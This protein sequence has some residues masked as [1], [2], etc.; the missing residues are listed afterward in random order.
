MAG[1]WFVKD[2]NT[3][4]QY[5]VE[6]KKFRSMWEATSAKAPDLLSPSQ[7]QMMRNWQLAKAQQMM[8][9]HQ[10]S[11]VK[12]DDRLYIKIGPQEMKILLDTFPSGRVDVDNGLKIQNAAALPA[13]K[14]VFAAIQNNM[15]VGGKF[16]PK[17]Y[18]KMG[19]FAKPVSA[20]ESGKLEVVEPE[21][22]KLAPT[23]RWFAFKAP[24]AGEHGIE[25]LKLLEGDYMAF[26]KQTTEVYRAERAVFEDNDKMQFEEITTEEAKAAVASVQA[27]IPSRSMC[28]PRSN[29]CL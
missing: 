16:L 12:P 15:E 22:D 4:A 29:C 3:E 25:Y 9:F 11:S 14:D 23:Q 6:D 28:A 8:F 19:V 5:T 7:K 26:K 27:A 2:L 1:F 20:N 24:W 10:S 17:A 18:R 21:C 13:N